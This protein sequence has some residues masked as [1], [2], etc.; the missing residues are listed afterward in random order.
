MK[1]LHMDKVHYY[2]KFTWCGTKILPPKMW[3][4]H[5]ITL[6]ASETDTNIL[7]QKCNPDLFRG[8]YVRSD[9]IPMHQKGAKNVV[10]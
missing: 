4:L 7:K 1:G 8:E 9:L 10:N 6:T 3:N 5:P 2:F